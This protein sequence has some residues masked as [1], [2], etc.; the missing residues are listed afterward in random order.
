MHKSVSIMQQVNRWRPAAPV[1]L[2]FVLSVVA[3]FGLTYLGGIGL[4]REASIRSRG[5]VSA[6][7]AGRL[8]VL[9]SIA[10]DYA[11]WD[12]AYRNLAVRFSIDWARTNLAGETVTNDYSEV[13][14]SLV[15]DQNGRLLCGFARHR[16]L[17]QD[18]MASLK[19]GLS[20]LVANARLARDESGAPIPIHGILRR[21]ERIILAAAAVITPFQDSTGKH[22]PATAPV[23]IIFTALNDKALQA[24]AAATMVANLRTS[25][26]IE[27][28]DIGLPLMGMDGSTQGYLVWSPPRPGQRL[29]DQ[30]K[31]PIALVTLLLAALFVAAM[32]QVLRAG[33]AAESYAEMVADKNKRLEQATNLMSVT[34]DSIDEGIVMMRND[35]Q[36]RYWNKTYERMWGLPTGF[37]KVGMTLNDVIAWKKTR[38]GYELVETD[39][40]ETAVDEAAQGSG[41]SPTPLLQRLYR[42]RRGRL[43]EAR[44]FLMPDGHGQIGVTR[45]LTEAKGREHALIEAREQADIANRAKSEFLANVSHELRTPLNTIIGFSEVLEGELYGPIENRR[46]RSYIRDVGTSGRHLLDLINGIL[47]FSKIEAG[48][49][50]L[51][52]EATDCS[53]VTRDAARQLSHQA[54][55][56]GIRFHIDVPPLPVLISADRRHIF[57]ALINLLSNAV[58]F[59]PGGGT[60]RLAYHIAEDGGIAFVVS[61]TGI[62]IADSDIPLA[63]EPFGQIDSDMAR[64]HLGTGLGLSIV[65]GICDLHGGRL[66]IESELGVGTTVV[67]TIPDQRRRRGKPEAGLKP[68]D[69]VKAD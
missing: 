22:D 40:D 3:V 21:G 50:K 9:E 6:Q 33:R 69:A 61:D 28:G 32:D 35:G 59:T 66:E 11:W 47:E 13:S 63:L 1:F 67:M 10:R 4:D 8:K 49:L 7:L 37:L 58:K 5:E 12:E 27:T 62:G 19:G 23:F 2:L 42:D 16:E 17:G 56:Q 54:A 64:R 36:I 60:V 48:K 34:V 52:L 43:I 44:R 39:E 15:V 57:Q 38:G 41:M 53:M 55:A 65:K 45:D 68:F 31:I 18:F 29:I 24:L 14:G 46:Y 26:R 30:L 25:D 51:R 20:P